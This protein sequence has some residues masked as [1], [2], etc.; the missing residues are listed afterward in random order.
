MRTPSIALFAAFVLASSGCL[1]RNPQT[2][3]GTEAASANKAQE[4]KLTP[5]EEQ[6]RAEGLA[7]SNAERES[8]MQAAHAAHA[9]A[10]PAPTSQPTTL[11]QDLRTKTRAQAYAGDT[12]A[13]LF[14][15]QSYA[16]SEPMDLV[17]AHAW[18]SLAADRGNTDAP[19][20]R[21]D[22]EGKL[23]PAQLRRAKRM[24]KASA[25]QIKDK[26]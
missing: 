21:D 2:S 1:G 22:L 14:L 23:S 24:A 19:A 26:D 18:A 25:A 15:A 9:A 12:F 13:M 20:L 16:S 6:L 17:R 10:A 7:M 3:E 4:R 8:R 5:F 11:A